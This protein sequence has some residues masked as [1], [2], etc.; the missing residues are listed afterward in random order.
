LVW[1]SSGLYKSTGDSPMTLND[2]DSNQSS[3]GRSDRSPLQDRMLAN[4]DFAVSRRD[5]LGMTAASLL[6]AG[7]LSAAAKP[8]RKS[9][10]PYRTLGRTGEKVSLIGLGGYHLGKQSDPEESIG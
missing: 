1:I 10:I 6:M 7:G 8:D 3:S 5:F 4:Q 2:S 9:G